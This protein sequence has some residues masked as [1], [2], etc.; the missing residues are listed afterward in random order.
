[1]D[2]SDS[3]KSWTM[4]RHGNRSMTAL[5]GDIVSPQCAQTRPRRSFCQGLHTVDDQWEPVHAIYAVCTRTRS[6]MFV[7]I[8]LVSSSLFFV[9]TSPPCFLFLQASLGLAL[10]VHGSGGEEEDTKERRRRRERRETTHVVLLVRAMC[11]P[12][13]FGW[14]QNESTTSEHNTNTHAF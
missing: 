5:H 6:T 7:G 9:F 1:M 2:S 10:L 12:M 4:V 8:S 3:A 13:T 14:F 11:I